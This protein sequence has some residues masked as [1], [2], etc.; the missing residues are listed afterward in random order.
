MGAAAIVAIAGVTAIVAGHGNAS[1]GTASPSRQPMPTGNLPGWR[2]AFADD[3]TH[4][5]PLG[6]FPAA[7]A[8]RW[9]WTYRDGTLDTVKNG[10]YMPTKVVSVNHGL[11]NIHLHSAG[12]VPLGAALVPTFPGTHGRGGGQLYGRYV[13]RFRT[14]PVRG[15]KMVILLWPDSGAWPRDGEIDFPEANLNS[16]IW[17]HVHHQGGTSGN[18]QTGFR[19][20]VMYAR[21]WHTAA[22]NWLPGKVILQLDGRTVGTSTTRIPNTPMHLVIQTET[23]TDGSVP[24]ASAAG[25]VQ[26]DWV[27]VY[28]R[29]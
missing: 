25:N 12:G 3:F 9:G 16:N 14:D 26:I 15:Y 24:T 18:D 23:S 21:G 22:I 5:V 10:A 2:R 8:R 7:V 4:S 19:T 27:V 20:P 1:S 17:G 29:V 13:I 28:R 11:L 6:R